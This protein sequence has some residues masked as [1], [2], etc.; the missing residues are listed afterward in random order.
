MS[1]VDP[2]I[3]AELEAFRQT[4]PEEDRCEIRDDGI[5]W[6]VVKARFLAK[7][8]H[9][10]L[11]MVDVATY[12]A[13]VRSISVIDEDHALSEQVDLNKPIIIIKWKNDVGVVKDRV[14][15]GSHRLFKAHHKGISTLPAYIL[16]TEE[17]RL[18]ISSH[19]PLGR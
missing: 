10:M 2:I 1:E 5:P 18:C 3:E 14:I 13:N 7:R 8:D 9:G 4:L 19:Y 15:D 12:W 6:D 11:E 16:S 17:G